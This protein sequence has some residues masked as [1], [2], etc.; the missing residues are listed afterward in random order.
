MSPKMHIAAKLFWIVLVCECH[1]FY[2]LNHTL[3]FSLP[4][5]LPGVDHLA[6]LLIVQ[7][8]IPTCVKLGE[9]NL[10]LLSCQVLTDCQELLKHKSNNLEIYR[11]DICTFLVTRPSPSLSMF[12]KSFSMCDS[13]PMNSSNDKQPS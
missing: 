13:S 1:C 12:L 6:E 3:L 5:H 10:N 11:F 8:V 4:L 2:N 7:L 9:S